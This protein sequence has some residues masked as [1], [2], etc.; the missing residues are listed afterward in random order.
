MFV[1]VL[2]LPFNDEHCN[3]TVCLL[4]AELQSEFDVQPEQ[5]CKLHIVCA[6]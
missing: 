2:S 4:F 6:L 5:S 1:T 3:C